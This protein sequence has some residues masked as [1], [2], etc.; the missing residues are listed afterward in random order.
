MAD[1][2]QDNPERQRRDLLMKLKKTTE[3]LLA[4]QSVQGPWGTYGALR[5]ICHDTESILCHRMRES[6]C[7][8]TL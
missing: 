8:R 7:V 4:G 6:K 1:V 3:S 5:R 2:E